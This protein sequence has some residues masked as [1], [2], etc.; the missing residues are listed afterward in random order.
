[1]ERCINH[2]QKPAGQWTESPLGNSEITVIHNIHQFPLLTQTGA[3]HK[4]IETEQTTGHQPRRSLQVKGRSLCY[5]GALV[6]EDP[7]HSLPFKKVNVG[8]EGTK[9]F[10]E[11]I[12]S[13]SERKV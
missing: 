10:S 4:V 9:R 11:E 7:V 2:R 5:T 1:M 13:G 8:S 12:N 6:T 3:L